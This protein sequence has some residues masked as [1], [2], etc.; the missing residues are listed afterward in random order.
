MNACRRTDFIMALP[1]KSICTGIIVFK[2]GENP[3]KASGRLL[4]IDGGFSKAYQERT[5]IAGYTLIFNSHG[6]LLA[7]HEPFAPT[8]SAIEE[9]RDMRTHT[10]ILETSPRRILIKD[11]E[12]GDAIR[13]QI[14]YLEALLTA[15]RAGEIQ[16]Q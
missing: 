11:I 10:E 9:S 1:E 13:K 5:G 6:L 8:Q 7:S 3:V 12:T 2:K 15:Y 4:V 16:Q 14:Q